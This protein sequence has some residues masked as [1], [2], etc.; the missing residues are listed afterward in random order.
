MHG[1]E[2]RTDVR[3]DD[4]LGYPAGLTE[5]RLRFQRLYGPWDA[6]DPPG[7][8]AAFEECGFAWWVAG[9]WAIEAFTGV[10]REHEDIDI[11]MFA[12]DLPLLREHVAGRLH[13]WAAGPTGLCPLDDSN[14][15]MPESSSQ[16]WLRAHALAPWRADVLLSPDR[17]GAWLSK[18]DPQHWAPLDQVTWTADGVRYLNPEI[19]LAFKAKL[20][21]PKDEVDL[22]ATLPLLGD[23]RRTWLADYIHRLHPGHAW[24][25]RLE[26]AET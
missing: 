24:S 4:S 2:D 23:E 6:F 12:K 13:V 18:R 22:S 5:S 15:T 16:V 14:M 21:R 11:A 20:A 26:R 17:D 3:S 10:P 9:G 8:R 25:A 7:A 1:T 19:V